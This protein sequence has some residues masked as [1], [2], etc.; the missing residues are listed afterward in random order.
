MKTQHEQR[1]KT[2]A[3]LAD[4]I[5]LQIIEVLLSCEEM[6][7]S[8]IAD[9]LGISLALF[10]HHSKTLAEAGLL[11][12]RKEGQTKYHSLNRSLL[13]NCLDSFSIK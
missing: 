7:G 1:A 9:K 5:R 12:K 6:S 2:F 3:A 10:C 13:A 8:D 11:E 4:P